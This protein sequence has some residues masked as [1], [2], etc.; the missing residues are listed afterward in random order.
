MDNPGTFS[1][2][3][4]NDVVCLCAM[5]MY[6]L[7]PK[8]DRNKICINMVDPGL[9]SPEFGRMNDATMMIGAMGVLSSSR[10]PDRVDGT[11]GVVNAVAVAGPRS[12]G[13]FLRDNT[14]ETYA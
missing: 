6:A 11:A 1:G 7:A 2:A 13:R 3:K 9:V 10:V 8:L 5:F 12:H 14:A 4:Y